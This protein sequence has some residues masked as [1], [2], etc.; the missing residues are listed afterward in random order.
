LTMELIVFEHALVTGA[1][2]PTVDAWAISN[3]IIVDK[4][5]TSMLLLCIKVLLLGIAPYFIGCILIVTQEWI[6]RK[7][8]I[9]RRLE[10]NCIF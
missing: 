5:K 3:P 1:I 4:Y 2:G 6:I 8:H 7:R 9:L 10:I